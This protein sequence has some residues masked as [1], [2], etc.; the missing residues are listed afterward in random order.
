M[1]LLQFEG[2][3]KAFS[4]LENLK[5]HLRSH[6]GEKPYLCQHPGCQ[7]AFSN[8][9]DRAK[10]QRTHLDTKPY[11]CQIPGCSKRYTDPSS[12]RKHVKAHSAKEQQVR[13]KLHSYSDAEQEILS[14]CLTMQQIHPSSQHILD[15]KCGRSM[16]HH[17]LITGCNKAFSRLENLK[18]HLRVIRHPGCQ[19]AFSNSS[20]RAKHQRTHLDTRYTDPS[21]LRKHVK[22][23]S[24]KEQQ[25]RKKLHSYSDAEQE[26][27]SECLTMQ[28]IHPSSQH[29]LDGKCGRS[30]SHH[31]LITGFLKEYTTPKNISKEEYNKANMFRP[32]RM[33]TSSSTNHNGPSPGLLPPHQN[34]LSRQHILESALTSAHHHVSSIGSDGEGYV[35]KYFSIFNVPTFCLLFGSPELKNRKDHCMQSY[36]F[37]LLLPVKLY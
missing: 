2:C 27:L 32:E 8:S 19:K 34:V 6:T 26:I 12:L 29:I 11:A 23:H 20:D 4:R 7:K 35:I 14:E 5:I 22:A 3:N 16:S 37:S 9:S 31:D 21:S 25:V 24:A 10:H 17:D 30:M 28:Q 1:A 33:Y 15:G 13:K 18:I 36:V